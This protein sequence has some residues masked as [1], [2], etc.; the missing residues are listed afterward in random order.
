VNND[1]VIFKITPAGAETVLYSFQGGTTDGMNPQGSLVQGTNGDLYGM[2]VLGG[3]G[4]FGTIFK[5]N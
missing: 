1:G 5:L 2:T 3:A 4:N